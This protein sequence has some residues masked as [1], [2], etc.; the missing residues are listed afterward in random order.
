MPI[1]EARVLTVT[2]LNKYVKMLIDGNPILSNVWVKGEISNL[3]CHSSGHLYFSLKDEGARVAAVMFRSA[4]DKLKFRP[5]NGMK[6]LLHGRVSVY[7]RDGAYQIY[8][9]SLEPDGVGA[10][11]IAY[12][13]LKRRLEAEGL[14]RQDR[15]K[16]L[17]KKR[18]K[19]I[20][21]YMDFTCVDSF[22]ALLFRMDFLP[23]QHS[24]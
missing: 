17:P 9:N 15:K 22:P 1:D 6:V 7:P 24:S 10:L 12:E 23:R 20:H 5:E 16:P 11:Y 2:K 4:A 13:Q 3:T 19:K 14:F 18:D 21:I 8:A